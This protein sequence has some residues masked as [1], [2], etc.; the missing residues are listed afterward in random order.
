V[1]EIEAERE[2]FE[3]LLLRQPDS[4]GVHPQDWLRLDL[5]ADN[6]IGGSNTGSDQSWAQIRRW[7]DTCRL[8]HANC[9]KPTDAPT[10]YPNR[11]LDLGVDQ[12][13]AS[14][15]RLIETKDA[16]PQG[17]YITLS[18]CWG[19]QPVI[20]L[21]SD[22]LATFLKKIDFAGLSKTF[23]DAVIATRK[24]RIRYLWIDSLCII[25]SGPDSNSDWLRESA[26]KGE[27]NRNAFLN[28]GATGAVDGNDGCFRDRD[29]REVFRPVIH[30]EECLTHLGKFHQSYRLVEKSFVQ[31]CL[32]NEPLLQR[33]WVYQER[34]P[35][36]RMLHYG[37]KQLFWECNE[38][39]A[40]ESFPTHVLSPIE[41]TSPAGL[42]KSV[43]DDKTLRRVIGLY[44]WYSVVEQ[45]TSM[46]LTRSE[47]KLVAIS[48]VAQQYQKV[49]LGG[50]DD[51]WVGTWHSDL[52]RGL[53]WRVKDG[54]GKRPE[55]FR[56]PSW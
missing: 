53:C 48:G 16:S 42:E 44:H 5:E 49:I 35:A 54:K 45:Y 22:N 43:G 18:H 41:L 8:G 27:V 17:N 10:S 15:I 33:G 23:Q 32:L 19:T 12:P 56:A 7:M 9:P 14:P 30:K 3:A 6:A 34:L 20:S 28:I 4:T 50:D 13:L 55:K 51:Y 26:T 37:T 36:P 1:R 38:M 11:L 25:Q 2:D 39:W 29:Y 52:P 47:D 40:C 31:D 21:T 24:M 46:V